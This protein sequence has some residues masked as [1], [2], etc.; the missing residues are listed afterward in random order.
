MRQWIAYYRDGTHLRQ[1]ENGKVNRYGDIDRSKLFAF[2]I[3]EEEKHLLIVH[4][5]KG[6][7]LIYRQRVERRPDGTEFRVWLVGCQHTE[8]GVNSQ[9]VS[10]LF[11]DGHVEIVDRF[12]EGA[13]WYH[14]PV[15]HPHEGEEWEHADTG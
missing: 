1:H 14:P 15:L 13:R 4:I 8:R 11:P 9:Y 12:Q 5:R 6:G 7:R 2:A 3:I 10:A